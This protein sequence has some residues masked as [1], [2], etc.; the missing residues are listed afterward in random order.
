MPK[1]K[2]SVSLGDVL[3][4]VQAFEDGLERFYT[5]V[6]DRSADNRVRMLTYY[7]ARH[8]RHGEL[9][10]A[11][12]SRARV[13]RLR[14]DAVCFDAARDPTRRHPLRGVSP[15]AATGEQLLASAV[16]YDGALIDLY[17]SL[18]GPSIGEGA[19]AVL[20]ALIRL[21]QRDLSMLKQMSAMNYF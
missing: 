12:L 6:R 7:M 15:A 5:R 10:V 18:M 8:R 13:S 14:R 21:E 2:A 9:A 16:C 11:G 17:R 20:E 1:A 19:R 3:D 4:R